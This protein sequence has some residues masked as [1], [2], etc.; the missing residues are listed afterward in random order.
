MSTTGWE[1]TPGEFPWPPP[2]VQVVSPMF[3]GALDI[4]W[5]DPS[6]LNTGKIAVLVPAT[7]SIIVAGTPDVLT[8]A[9]GSITVDASPVPAGDTIIINGV[10]L[11]AAGGPRTPGNNNFDGTLGTPALIAADMQDAINDAANLFSTT[12]TAL[13]V[14]ATVGLTAATAGAAGNSISLFSASAC[15]TLSGAALTGGLDADTITIGGTYALTA[16]T[17]ARTSGGNDFSVDG[18]TFAIG[19]SIA[20]A[21]TDAANDFTSLVSAVSNGAGLVILTANG[22][23]FPGIQGNLISLVTSAAVLTLSGAT[24]SGGS[25]FDN[26]PGRNNA[27][28]NIIGVNVYRS[29]NGERGPYQRINKFPIGSMFFRDYTDNVLVEDEL[30]E[31]DSA[32]LDKGDAPNDRKWMFRTRHFPIVKAAGQ[33]IHASSPADVTLK[34]DGQVVPVEDVFGPRGEVTLINQRV[35]DLAR[36][37]WIEPALPTATGLV[38]ITYRYNR[39]VVKTDLDRNSKVFYRVVTVAVDSSSPSGLIETPLGY[40]PPV[41]VQQVETLDYIWR[42]AVSR[43]QWILEQGG[44]RV[45]LFLKKSTGIPCWCRGDTRLMEYQQQPDM[46]CPYCYG[47]GFVGAYDG[48]IDIIIAPDEAD[49]RISQTPDGRRME[50]QYEVWI[51]PSPVVSQRDFIVKQT[52]ERYSIGP[53][54]RPAARGLPLQQHFTI[55]YIDEQDVRYQ[56]PVNGITELPWPQTRTTEEDTECSPAEPYPVGFDYQATP[57]ETD[58]DNIPEE[59][60]QRGRTPVW[61]NITF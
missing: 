61:E 59:R 10:T 29:D 21:I 14:G 45:K 58:K 51:G 7:G 11:R 23:Y 40:A 31:W 28:W 37:R 13:A 30:V 57:M 8:A 27:Q 12:I 38:Q 53:V 26:C 43:N 55:A 4:R 42:A 20:A 15:V 2:N 33:A 6:L 19:D 39:N 36:E 17:G 50:H 46:R 34:I 5:D 56:I 24:L 60:Q 52:G 9:T 54:R 49:R 1:T 22:S 35:W 25:G 44:E 18:T 47:T 48:P 3:T 32:W 41:S 16:V